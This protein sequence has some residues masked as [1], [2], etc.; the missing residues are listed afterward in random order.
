[1]AEA[2]VELVDRVLAGEERAASQLVEQ[3]HNPVFRLCFRLV[4]R[5]EDAEDVVQESFLRAWKSLKSWDSERPFLPWIMAI[6]ANRCRTL[7]ARRAK[8]PLVYHSDAAADVAEAR[9]LD[10]GET[11]ELIRSTLSELR[12]DHAEAFR[13]FHEQELSYDEIADRMNRPLGTVKTWI[14]RA[15]RDLAFRLADME[16]MG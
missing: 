3:F 10:S 13:L 8:A 14:H 4:G 15:R 9:P 7:L 11:L 5:R 2:V 12:P 16:L 1:M 6:A